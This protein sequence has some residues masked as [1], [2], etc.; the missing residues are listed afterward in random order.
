VVLAPGM[1]FSLS[2]SMYGLRFIP[3][4]QPGQSNGANMFRIAN[5]LYDVDNFWF[6][7]T[8]VLLPYF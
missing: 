3:W 6:L 2:G 4:S 5:C 1:K 8:G 7:T